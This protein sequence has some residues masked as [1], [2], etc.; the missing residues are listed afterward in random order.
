M[1]PGVNPIAVNKY[2]NIN[3]NIKTT[4]PYRGVVRGS[5]S[6]GRSHYLV[7]RMLP[8]ASTP[9]AAAA[10]LR[11]RAANRKGIHGSVVRSETV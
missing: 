10:E 7:K 1:P 5:I 4:L 6:L 2:I 8:A 3:N 9:E 11:L